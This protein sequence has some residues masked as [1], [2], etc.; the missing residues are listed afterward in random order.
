MSGEYC[1][2]CGR[3]VHM[4]V[5]RHYCQGRQSTGADTE[6]HGSDKA[7]PAVLNADTRAYIASLV[8]E[9]ASMRASRDALAEALARLFAAADES[10]AVLAASED[11]LCAAANDM[12]A[13]PIV[14]EQAAA[15]LQ[16]RA[17]LAGHAKG[18]AS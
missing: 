18:E 14:R 3:F 12:G 2:V 8:A 5:H 11:D 9:L 6:R 4:D 17:V 16:C 13:D 15:V 1:D 10:G 7:I